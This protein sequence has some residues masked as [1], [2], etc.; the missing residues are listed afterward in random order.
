MPKKK[1]T[2]SF[3][4]K[5]LDVLNKFGVLPPF[6][7]TDE[8]KKI[9]K[10]LERDGATEFLDF[11]DRYNLKPGK[12]KKTI[13]KLAEIGA[14]EFEDDIVNITPVAV[15]YLHTTKKER[16][17]AKKFCKFIDAL[18]EKELDEFMKLVSAFVV[19]PEAAAAE[20]DVLEG[21]EPPVEE[22]KEVAPAEPAPAKP[23][24]AP[25]AP[26]AKKPAA[27]KKATPAKKAVKH[28]EEEKPDGEE[29]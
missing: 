13:K 17:S 14:V 10:G 23:K 24:R 16:K 26:A 18:S 9:I 12:A 25:R 29:I 19:D 6:H 3:I 20:L 7:F 11:C 5:Y 2:K 21:K 8:E 1:D 27:K 15:R 28:K 4:K 22:A